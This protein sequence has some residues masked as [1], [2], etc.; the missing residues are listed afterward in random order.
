MSVWVNI[1]FKP[2]TLPVTLSLK[3]KAADKAVLKWLRSRA[4]IKLQVIPILSNF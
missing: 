2:F 4:R 3:I 1:G